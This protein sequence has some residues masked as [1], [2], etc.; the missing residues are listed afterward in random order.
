MN[1]RWVRC[2]HS[3]LPQVRNMDAF[4][5][6]HLELCVT[7]FQRCRFNKDSCLY[8]KQEVMQFSAALHP[9]LTW[10]IINHSNWNRLCECTFWVWSQ[11]HWYKYVCK[12]KRFDSRFTLFSVHVRRNRHTAWDKDNKIWYAQKKKLVS[13]AERWTNNQITIIIMF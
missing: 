6:S 1:S 4:V 12:C 5:N 11:S 3:S 2:V 9:T 7:L 13:I 10:D 8:G